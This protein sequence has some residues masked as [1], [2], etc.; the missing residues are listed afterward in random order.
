MQNGLTIKQIKDLEP[1]LKKLTDYE[2][3]TKFDNAK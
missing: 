1:S 3:A 2:V